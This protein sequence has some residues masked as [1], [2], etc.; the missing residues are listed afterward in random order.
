ATEYGPVIQ[1]FRTDR[2]E[3][4]YR[5]VPSSIA[6]EEL[7]RLR[8]TYQTLLKSRDGTKFW[9]SRLREDDGYCGREPEIAYARYI[10]GD[11]WKALLAL[12]VIVPNNAARQ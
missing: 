7:S 8:A 1:L 4:T 6:A 5:E 3:H 2:L 11:P 12:L 10:P 9:L